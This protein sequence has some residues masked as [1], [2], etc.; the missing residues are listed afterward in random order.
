MV[1][2][3]IGMIRDKDHL[4][5]ELFIQL[6]K[7]AT[8]NKSPKADS[9]KRCWDLM[10]I[11][12]T[13]SFPSQGFEPYFRS[14]LHTSASNPNKDIAQAAHECDIRLTKS[15]MQ[16][17]ALPPL[18]SEI[19]AIER[20]QQLPLKVMFPEETSKSILFDS[21]T[22]T[23]EIL[24]KIFEKYDLPE[25]NEYGLYVTLING[26]VALPVLPNDKIMDIIYLAK[27]VVESERQRGPLATTASGEAFQIEFIRKLWLEQPLNA[28][29]SLQN[30]IYHQIRKEFVKGTL[31]SAQELNAKYMDTLAHLIAITFRVS[32]GPD[33]TFKTGDKESYFKDFIP[34]IANPKLSAKDWDNKISSELKK[35]NGKSDVGLRAEFLDVVKGWDLF[36]SSFFD[37]LASNDPRFSAGGLLCVDGV[38][39]RLLDR[40]TKVRSPHKKSLDSVISICKI[41]LLTKNNNFKTTGG[42]RFV[43]L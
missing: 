27:M 35:M 24:K 28:S 10:V 16:P 5:D 19:E 41:L 30:L 22:T 11:V 42:H 4:R 43:Q 31:L 13:F 25:S 34:T 18:E 9:L 7:Q 8:N 33:A 14:F 1:I 23:R 12:T 15:K 17:R 26:F 37:I 39:V 2:T 6:M 21:H 3:Q 29:E 40:K 36:G 32:K 38:G 20:K